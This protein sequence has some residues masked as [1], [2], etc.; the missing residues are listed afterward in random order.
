MDKKQFIDFW[1]QEGTPWHNYFSH[2]YRQRMTGMSPLLFGFIVASG[3][4]FLNDFLIKYHF[5]NFIIFV[6]CMIATWILLYGAL[7]IFYTK[8]KIKKEKLVYDDFRTKFLTP[9]NLKNIFGFLAQYTQEHDID[10]IEKIKYF[11]E[12]FKKEDITVEQ[13]QE[14]FSFNEDILYELED[15][16]KSQDSYQELVNQIGFNKPQSTKEKFLEML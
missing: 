11:F 12:M 14:F 3:G 13:M 6:T 9:D 2:E 10:R 5:N 4:G 15:F 8:P 1:N 16:E 7:N